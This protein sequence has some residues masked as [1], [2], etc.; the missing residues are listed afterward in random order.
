MTAPVRPSAQDA[1]TEEE[2]ENLLAQP[3]S[4]LSERARALR[5][6]GV[7]IDRLRR[8]AASMDYS[9]EGTPEERTAHRMDIMQEM[10]PARQEA[11]R[12]R[13]S[14]EFPR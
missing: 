1:L 14:D 3:K 10:E 9:C 6:A 11:T 12:E 5:Q 13:L 2:L 8:I 4:M 7:P